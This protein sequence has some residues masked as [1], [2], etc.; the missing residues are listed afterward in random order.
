MLSNINYLAHSPSWGLHVALRGGAFQYI[1]LYGIVRTTFLISSYSCNLSVLLLLVSSNIFHGLRCFQCY[2]RDYHK[3]KNC[4]GQWKSNKPCY[5][6][7]MQNTGI[8]S[9]YTH[10]SIR[11]LYHF[12]NTM[13]KY[14]RNPR[15]VACRKVLPKL[16]HFHVSWRYGPFLRATRCLIFE[17]K[18]S[19]VLC[20]RWTGTSSHSGNGYRH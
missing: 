18:D 19:L 5:P 8:A 17:Y 3:F 7:I 15:C 2:K 12:R 11:L 14:E 4:C 9:A 6:S 10:P 1:C 13:I 20:I 16:T